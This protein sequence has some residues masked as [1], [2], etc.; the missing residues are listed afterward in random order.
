VADGAAQCPVSR[1]ARPDGA[2]ASGR[3]CA[4]GFPVTGTVEEGDARGE[5]VAVRGRG[6]DLAGSAAWLDADG[7]GHYHVI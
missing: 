6:G 4:E 7:V 3:W 1:A 5:G 2:D